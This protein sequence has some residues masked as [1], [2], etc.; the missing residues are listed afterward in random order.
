MKQALCGCAKVGFS[1]L[2][3][4][5]LQLVAKQVKKDFLQKPIMLTEVNTPA[6]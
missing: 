3:S 5:S 1:N 4:L 2:V 6:V